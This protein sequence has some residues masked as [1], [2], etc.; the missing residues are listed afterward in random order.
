MVLMFLSTQ[1][2]AQDFSYKP[3]NPSFGGDSFNSSHLL[4]LAE[5]Q[6][7]FVP[8]PSTSDPFSNN[9]SQLFER[10]IQSALLSRI[11][12]QIVDEILGE[13]ASESGNFSIGGT[14]ID[15]ERI[16]GIIAITISD[17]LSGGSTLIEIPVPDF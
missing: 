9:N 2:M 1:L 3:V 10:Q 4:S 14:Q 5:R 17:D 16:D 11:S 6:N 8:G 12:A 15:F 7:M 13:T